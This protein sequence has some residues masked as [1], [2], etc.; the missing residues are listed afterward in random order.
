MFKFS[1]NLA[2]RPPFD[3]KLTVKKPAGWHW[4]VPGEFFEDGALY[5]ALRL[6]NSQL[7]GLKLRA[8]KSTVRVVAWSAEELSPADRRGLRARMI[9]GLGLKDDLEAFYRLA[10]GDKLV[11]RITRD[12]YG[13]NVGFPGDVFERAL[14]AVTLQMAPTERSRKMMSCLIEAYGQD[15]GADGRKIRFWPSPLRIAREPEGRLKQRCV[16]GYRAGAVRR[17]ASEVRSGFPDILELERSSPADALNR[18]KGLYGVGDYS[19]Q[20]ISPHF[21]FP[22]D[23]WSARIFHEILFGSTPARPR[24][25]IEKVTREAHR[26]WGRFKRHVF[27]YALHDLP[28]LARFYPIS[29]Q[30]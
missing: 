26:R 1:F 23:V 5:T 14:L 6:A 11:A 9:M 22:L 10:R 19:A 20:I 27:V 12:L 29:R 3:F 28:N 4:S 13:M 25:A 30:T 15:V 18:L 24:E 21:G 16:L 7:L 2:V 17:I 8:V